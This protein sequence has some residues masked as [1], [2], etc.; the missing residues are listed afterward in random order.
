MPKILDKNALRN[1]IGSQT[2]PFTPDDIA[3]SSSF[4]SS[5]AYLMIKEMIGSGNIILDHK[6]G[7]R[8]FYK[9]V[10]TGG[11]ITKLKAGTN[12][13]SLTPAERFKYVADLTD[14]VIGGITPSLLVTG[15]SGIGKTFL[16][17]KQLEDNGKVEGE[18]FHFIQGHSTPMGLYR[19]L[20]EHQDATVV[21]DDCDS[22][23][24]EETA[25]NILKSALD[26]YDVRKVSWCSGKLPE[27]LEGSFNFEGQIIFISN[28]DSSRI[29]E[30]VKS[31]TMVIDLQ[32]SRAEICDHLGTIAN[33][34]EPKIDIKSKLE[35]LEYLR[36]KM[37]HF[38]Q[39]NI[40]TFIKACRIRKCAEKNKSDWKKM[41][42]VL[43]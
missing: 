32:M 21:F 20:Y 17:K 27:D 25:I 29:D 9:V 36:E 12:I 34:I 2:Q 14:M 23:F 37:D 5:T 11:M 22:V 19:F 7:R 35:V 40:R 39:L 33:V 8:M 28:M 15:I 31:R 24:K 16:V 42:L 18:D 41:I 6:D 3:R 4:S 26:S 43:N 38:E 10:G 30:A 13:M 1:L